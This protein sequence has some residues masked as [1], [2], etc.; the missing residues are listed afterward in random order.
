MRKPD[1]YLTGHG[2]WRM[3]HEPPAIRVSTQVPVDY[4]GKLTLRMRT[5]D[6][7]ENGLTRHAVAW[8]SF[9]PCDEPF[10]VALALMVFIAN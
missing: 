1:L 5:L 7:N 9:P 10:L 8:I 3:F 6:R 4:R 2:A